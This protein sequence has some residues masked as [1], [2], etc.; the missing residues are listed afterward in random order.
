VKRLFAV[1]QNRCAFPKCPIPAHDGN[2]VLVQVCHIEGDKP[3][4]ARYRAEQPDR[5]RHGF[6]NL[7]LLCG[8][9]R[10]RHKSHYAAYRIM[11]RSGGALDEDAVVLRGII[12]AR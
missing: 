5:E 8:L 4:S 7:V 1:S 6:T 2:S 10:A 9:C 12:R 11:P 3:G